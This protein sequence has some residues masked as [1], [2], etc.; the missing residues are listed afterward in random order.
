MIALL[1]A[2]LEIGKWFVRRAATVSGG[3]AIVLAFG[4]IAAGLLTI[5]STIYSM[6]DSH[7]PDWLIAA[8]SAFGFWTTLDIVFGT[9]GTALGIRLTRILAKQ[10]ANTVAPTGG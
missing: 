9:I 3:V 1:E 5:R 10:F 2:I 4:G 6:V 7:F 8:A